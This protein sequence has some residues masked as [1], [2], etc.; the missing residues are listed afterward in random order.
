MRFVDM[1]LLKSR[2]ISVCLI[3]DHFIVYPCHFISLGVSQVAGKVEFMAGK[4]VL[5][6]L[7]GQLS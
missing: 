3:C 7:G 1:L 4:A 5:K 2:K 6:M